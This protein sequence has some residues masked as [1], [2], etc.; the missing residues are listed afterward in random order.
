MEHLLTLL[1]LCERIQHRLLSKGR[2]IHYDYVIINLFNLVGQYPFIPAS[3]VLKAYRHL[4][5]HSWTN[6]IVIPLDEKEKFTA[7]SLLSQE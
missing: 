5:K 3:V 7:R 1:G 4:L 6:D 2:S